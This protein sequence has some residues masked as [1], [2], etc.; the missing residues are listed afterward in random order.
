MKAFGIMLLT[1]V[2][3]SVTLLLGALSWNNTAVGLENTTVAQVQQN[4]NLY[5]GFWKKVKEVAQVTQEYKG[6]SKDLYIGL[7]EARYPKG[8]NPLMKRI[9]ESNPTLDSSIYKKV[10]DVIETGRNEF[11][12]GQKD[13]ADKQ[14]RFKDHIRKL[15]GSLFANWFGFPSEQTGEMIP[16][17]DIDGDGKLTVLDY[18][19]VTSTKTEAVFKA[20]KDD[21]PLDVFGKKPAEAK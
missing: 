4:M 6:D 12:Q 3:I 17:K 5:D 19:I 11:M 9:Q 18:P 7:M 2:V 14:R 16:S 21:E 8:E 20:G 15:P 10:Q 13:L 1:F